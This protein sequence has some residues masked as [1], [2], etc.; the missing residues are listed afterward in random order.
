MTR[1]ERVAGLLD[2]ETRNWLLRNLKVIETTDDLVGV[3]LTDRGYIL[4]LG[5]QIDS[6][7][8]EQAKIV[9]LHEI[10][11]VLR[12]DCLGDGDVDPGLA[13]IAKDSIINCGFPDFKSHFPSGPPYYWD[14]AKEY[15]EL[16]S[17][18]IPGWKLIYDVLKKNSPPMMVSFDAAP[19][20]K[21]SSRKKAEQI[22]AK[23]VLEARKVEALKK[24]GAGPLVK[25]AYQGRVKGQ[26]LPPWARLLNKITRKVRKNGFGS[27]VHVR[28]YNRPGRVEGL[29]GV[30]RQPRLTIEVILD[31]SGSCSA[32]E[33]VFRGLAQTLKR[34]YNVRLGVFANQFAEIKRAGEVPEVGGGT[35]IRPVMEALDKIRPDLAIIL[36]D[37]DFFDALELPTCPVWFVIYGDEPK[38]A[39]SLRPKDKIIMGEEVRG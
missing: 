1:V 33:P 24:L 39:T 21:T 4:A 35:E 27:L 13:N 17:D 6:Y 18:M 31:V 5:S 34:H 10:A 26:P 19:Q 20:N 38:W 3:A 7:N 37:G 29:R 9:L 30:A 11:H 12:G 14:L 32:L 28:T 16:P 22:H 15:D 2:K 25:G 23:V 8:D 36:T